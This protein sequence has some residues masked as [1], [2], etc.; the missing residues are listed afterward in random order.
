MKKMMNDDICI[1]CNRL[2]ESHNNDERR[3]CA[4]HIARGKSSLGVST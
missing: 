4:Y 3:S 2:I 1:F